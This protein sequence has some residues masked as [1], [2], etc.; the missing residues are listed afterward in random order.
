MAMEVTPRVILVGGVVVGAVNIS[1][2]DGQD[3][4]GYWIGR[5]HWG[6]G[7]AS[8]AVAMVLNEVTRRPL[9]ATAAEQNAASIQVLQKNGFE[10]VARLMTPETPRTVQRESVLHVL[11]RGGAR[12]PCV[13][14]SGVEK[15]DGDSDGRP[16]RS[17]SK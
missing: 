12:V 7:I 8:R 10:V 11:K 17:R 9:H 14:E 5:A 2:S 16:G 3:S 4:L 15:Q 1:P 13:R 6:R